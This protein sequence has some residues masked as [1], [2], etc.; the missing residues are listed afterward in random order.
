MSK[1]ERSRALVQRMP[2]ASSVVMIE[3]GLA[4]PVR[5]VPEKAEHAIDHEG[6]VR[7]CEFTGLRRED[8]R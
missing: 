4:P 6:D 7:G 2:L 8:V 5:I 1:G 3:Q